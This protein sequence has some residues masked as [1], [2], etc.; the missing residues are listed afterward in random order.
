MS[1]LGIDN[2]L[3]S[4]ADRDIIAAWTV[5]ADR[6]MGYALALP[7]LSASERFEFLA[8]GDSGDSDASGPRL[9]PQ[10]AVARQMIADAALPESAGR[11]VMV[12]HT[13]DVVYMTGEHRL[14][15]RNFRRP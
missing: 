14:Y 4:P 11:A 12:L 9:S 2:W 10:N 15:D 5:G 3:K 13:G 8:L 1:L 7:P 6:E